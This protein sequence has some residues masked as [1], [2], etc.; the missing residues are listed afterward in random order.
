MRSIQSRCSDMSGFSR[1]PAPTS[2]PLDQ[3]LPI[4]N[5]PQTGSGTRTAA[6]HLIY[7]AIC[8]GVI[9]AHEI[10]T[11][12]ILLQPLQRLAGVVRQQ[13]IQA[14][15]DLEDLASMDLDIRGLALEATKRLVNHDARVR[16]RVALAL[17]TGGQQ[18]GAHARGLADTHG[19]DIRLDELHGV[20]DRHAG[21]DRATRAVD[22]Q[23]DVL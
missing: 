8:L 1:P 4:T 7:N 12:G 14:T 18:E 21:G 13:F 22:I 5:W 20:V 19:A 17:D 2:G 10:V 23:V 11:V 15:L 9:G 6:K 3:F 16:Q